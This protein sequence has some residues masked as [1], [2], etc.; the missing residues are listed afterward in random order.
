MGLTMVNIQE[1]EQARELRIYLRTVGDLARLHIARLLAQRG[2][3]SEIELVTALRLSQPLVSWHLGVMRR[4]DLV[5]VRREGRL[6][7]YSLKRE[8]WQSFQQRLND[9]LNIPQINSEEN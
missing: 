4:I 1:M 8:T 9:W 3:M 7:Y 6:V 5:Q 2:E